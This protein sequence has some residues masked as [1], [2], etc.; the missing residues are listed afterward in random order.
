MA[1]FSKAASFGAALLHFDGRAGWFCLGM[2]L[3]N[4]RFRLVKLQKRW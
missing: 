4:E 2:R 3:Q 1:L